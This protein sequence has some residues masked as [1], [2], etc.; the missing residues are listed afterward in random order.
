[1][2]SL[3]KK[4]SLGSRCSCIFLFSWSYFFFH[5][6]NNF[7]VLSFFF[8]LYPSVKHLL[9][10]ATFFYFTSLE[11]LSSSS[12][13]NSFF[14]IHFFLL[15]VQLFFWDLFLFYGHSSFGF[16]SSFFASYN[17]GSFFCIPFFFNILFSRIFFFPLT[18]FRSSFNVLIL[19]VW[20]IWRSSLLPTISI[21]SCSPLFLQLM[22]HWRIS[23]IFFLIYSQSQFLLVLAHYATFLE[24]LLLSLKQYS[25]IRLLFFSFSSYNF[26]L[27]FYIS[28]LFL[29]YSS[30]KHSP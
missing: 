8:R 13:V 7:K 18:L 2:V 17:L 21:I 16:L 28:Y 24:N 29:Q 9:F 10:G 4:Y 27:L 30:F 19:L 22:F 11:K 1:M 26:I 23:C 15:L 6:H 5:G 20:Q 14:T 3:D 25:G 12:V